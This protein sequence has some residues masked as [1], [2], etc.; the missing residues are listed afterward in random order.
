L[1]WNELEFLSWDEFKQ[2]APSIVQLEISRISKL[3]RASHFE[4]DFHN[5]LVKA[6]F[7]LKKFVACVDATMKSPLDEACVTQLQAAILILVAA[8]TNRP[9]NEKRTIDSI[10]DRLHDVYN[11]CKMLY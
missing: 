9:S 10:L 7:E 6:R 8:K 4:I 2:M 1:D 11:R 5:A 3:I